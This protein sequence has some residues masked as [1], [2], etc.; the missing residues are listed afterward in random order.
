VSQ[1]S[2]SP[3]FPVADAGDVEDRVPKKQEP[4]IVGELF[5]GHAKRVRRF[6]GFR[7]RNHEDAQDATQDIFLR[8]WKYERQGTLRDEARNYM[9]SATH[10]V[11]IDVE[12]HRAHIGQEHSADAEPDSIARPGPSQDDILHWRKAMEAFVDIINVL[13]EVT[14]DVFVLYHFQNM[15]YDEVAKHLGVSRRT[16]ERHLATALALCRK[17]MERYL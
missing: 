13:P 3:T 11:A 15:G 12:R 14:R 4:T 7:L 10:S 17:D 16:V 2:D 9:L 5:N 6:L 1:A 8:L